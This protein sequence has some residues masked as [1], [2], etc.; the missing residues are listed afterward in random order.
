MVTAMSHL[1]IALVMIAQQ[2]APPASTGGELTRRL[3]GT[4]AAA[5]QPLNPTP[6]PVVTRPATAPVTAPATVPAP[7]P[8]APSTSTPSTS[9]PS[10]VRPTPTSVPTTTGT[11]PPPG[12]ATPRSAPS[13]T[14]TP[15]PVATVPTTGSAVPTNAPEA[16]PVEPPAPPPA[17]LDA[18]AIAALPFTLSL[19]TGFSITTERPGPG[20]SIYTIRRGGQPFVMVYTGA[21]SQFPI[22]SGEMVEAGGRT[23]IVAT[24]DGRRVA[25][26]HLFTR[27]TAPRAI[28][29][30]ITSL[31]GPDRLVAERIGQSIDAR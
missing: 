23:S 27:A 10:A 4:P 30:W 19:P 28:H 25:L 20:F 11:P 16:A 24:E 18:R 14:P 12:T 22:Y 13:S 1:L 5:T 15:A 6:N 9:T 26:E 31:E 17:V 3:N 2:T 21:D 29:I 8:T 7:R